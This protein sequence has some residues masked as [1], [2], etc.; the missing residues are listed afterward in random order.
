[1]IT[2]AETP[3][4]AVRPIP[5]PTQGKA[6]ESG[7]QPPFRSATMG[8]LES[9]SPVRWK[10][11][12]IT[13]LWAKSL[14]VVIAWFAVPYL[15]RLFHGLVGTPEA[16]NVAGDIV[17]GF[18]VIAFG[19]RVFRARGEAIEPR[20]VWWRATGRPAAGFAL[21]AA[22]AVP[23]LVVFVPSSDGSPAVW[24]YA[25]SGIPIAAF[26]LHSSVRLAHGDAP[27]PPRSR[28][29]DAARYLSRKGSVV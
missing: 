22:F 7:E 26:Y 5:D 13:D 18:V 6:T 21:F 27:L 16:L 11:F 3:Q 10:P 14:F 19:T 17:F 12:R 2:T 23:V 9:G 29:D 24:W 1:M 8:S 15:L 4:R 25:L 28:R 20:R